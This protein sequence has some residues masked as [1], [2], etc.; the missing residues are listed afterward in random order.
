MTSTDAPRTLPLEGAFN[1]R[2]LGGYPAADGRRIRWRTL[3]RS[4]GLGALTAGDVDHLREIGLRTVVDLRTSH[5]IEERGR[6]PLDAH[7]VRF[8]HLSVID[9]TWDRD[10]VARM[11]F[12]TTEFLH[13]AY[14]DML[15]NGGERFAAA[16]SLLAE[17]EALPAVFHCAAGKDRTGLLAALV[18]GA[19]DID[20]EAI[21]ADYALT[22]VAMQR[23][24]ER[25][26]EDPERAAQM[27]AT[28]SSFYAADAAAMRRVLDD[29]DTD[30]GSVRAFVRHLGVGDGTVERLAAAL[31]TD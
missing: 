27:D 25:M 5:E 16:F 8:H 7:P 11:E 12:T 15:R 28:P 3:F 30:H 23:I 21:V 17:H 29:I 31:L 18:L 20:R 6:Y 9:T 22:E 19:L 1:F 10:A 13:W 24:I 2:D 4:D 14:T 26:R